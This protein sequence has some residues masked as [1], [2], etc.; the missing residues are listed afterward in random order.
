MTV[1]NK[2][3]RIYQNSKKDISKFSRSLV[4][5]LHAAC[6]D[7]TIDQKNTPTLIETV[8]Y[9]IPGSTRRPK[10]LYGSS[11]TASRKMRKRR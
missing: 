1:F 9:L 11:P 5:L 6:R 3:N 10:N 4:W 2:L 7:S 8:H